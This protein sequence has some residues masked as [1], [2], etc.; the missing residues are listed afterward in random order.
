LAEL[1]PKEAKGGAWYGSKNGCFPFSELCDACG[2]ALS[3]FLGQ[4]Q[5]QV[6]LAVQVFLGSSQVNPGWA[7]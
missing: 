5:V 4:K 6:F 1:L 7:G 2:L 3:Y